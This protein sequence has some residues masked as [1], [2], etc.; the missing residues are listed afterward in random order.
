MQLRL[1]LP[2]VAL[3]A[4]TLIFACKKNNTSN[5]SLLQHKWDITSLNGE[6][7]RYVGNS[8]DYFDFQNGQLIEYFGG[9]YDTL[10]YTFINN[11]MT[12]QLRTVTDNV[13]NS[14]PFDL[15]IITL[16]SNRLI[17]TESPSMPNFPV[18]D[19]LSR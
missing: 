16:T 14:T 19:S 1:I 3:A 2:A 5:P 9:K 13:V 8:S 6:A 15:T 18:L 4:C 12:L 10:D 17:L 7:F 11:N